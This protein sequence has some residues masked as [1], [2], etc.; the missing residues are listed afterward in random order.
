MAHNRH[1]HPLIRQRTGKDAAQPLF[2]AI[3]KRHTARKLK[4]RRLD[5]GHPAKQR[6]PDARARQNRRKT[7][8]NKRAAG[9]KR[10][11]LLL[12]IHPRALLEIRLC[13][14]VR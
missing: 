14:C 10:R 4:V 8:G 2:L 3:G 7:T 1:M 12:Y 9:Q 6:E 13:M 5:L 11:V